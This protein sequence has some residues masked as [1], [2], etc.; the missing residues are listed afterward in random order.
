MNVNFAGCAL[1]DSTWGN[2]W[3]EVEGE[4]RFFCCELCLRQFRNLL[5]R[6]KLETGWVHLDAVEIV[7]DRSG[8]TCTAS[9]GSG[10]LRVR[11]AFNAEGTLRQ[12]EP[13]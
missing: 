9:C 3:A 1:C 12:F 13:F 2:V 7:G 10:T 11:V 6:V 5:A 8:R 4:R